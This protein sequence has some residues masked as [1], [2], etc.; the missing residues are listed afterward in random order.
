[1]KSLKRIIINTIETCQLLIN[2]IEV[3]LFLLRKVKRQMLIRSKYITRS[4]EH[5]SMTDSGKKL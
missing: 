2:K 4:S 3:V 5:R 1:M